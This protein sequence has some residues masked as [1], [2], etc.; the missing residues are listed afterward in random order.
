MSRPHVVQHGTL[1][2][3]KN[4]GCRCDECRAANAENNR[5][6]LTAPCSNGCGRPA[7]QRTAHG[8]CRACASE[9]QRK[10]QIHGTENSYDRYKCRC[11]EC[12]AAAARGRRH[13]RWMKNERSRSTAA[14]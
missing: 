8:R 6:R 3:Y 14:A 1:N 9:A 5:V 12:R 11:S 10:P 2:E 7:W 13:R 4:F